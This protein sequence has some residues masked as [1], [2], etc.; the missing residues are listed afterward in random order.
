MVAQS[1]P[2]T[3]KAVS[4]LAARAFRQVTIKEPIARY[5]APTVRKL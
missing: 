3:P 4:W 5:S 1:V 2:L